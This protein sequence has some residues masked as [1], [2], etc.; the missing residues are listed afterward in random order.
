MTRKQIVPGAVTGFLKGRENVAA[1]V[2][3][4]K[5]ALENC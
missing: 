5:V 1:E 4:K 3:E 2:V